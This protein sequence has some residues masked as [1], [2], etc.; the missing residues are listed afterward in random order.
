MSDVFAGRIGVT[1]DQGRS[2]SIDR[3]REQ[4]PQRVSELEALYR[5]QIRAIV[6]PYLLQARQALE[7]EGYRVS[8]ETPS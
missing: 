7:A 6:R 1:L 8:I 5:D 2:F 4:S 3:A